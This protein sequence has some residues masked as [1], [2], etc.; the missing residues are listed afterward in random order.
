VA[1]WPGTVNV[2]DASRRV[3]QVRLWVDYRRITEFQ[4][5]LAHLGSAREHAWHPIAK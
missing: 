3:A 5:V 1:S 4:L 2:A